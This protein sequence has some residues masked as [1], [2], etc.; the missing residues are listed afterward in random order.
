MIYTIWDFEGIIPG[1]ADY[2]SALLLKIAIIAFVIYFSIIEG[3]QCYREG[4][5]DH[6]KSF[7]N[8]LDLV[9]PILI[10]IAEATA[11]N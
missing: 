7:W 4:L 11:I 1:Q 6:L 5:K 9:P 2:T 3:I 8:Y 10:V